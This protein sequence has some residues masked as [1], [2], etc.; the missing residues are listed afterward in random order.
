VTTQ[1]TA[2]KGSNRT[3]KQLLQ[4]ASVLDPTF[5]APIITAMVIVSSII[6]IGRSTS[7]TKNSKINPQRFFTVSGTLYYIEWLAFSG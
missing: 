5:A 2:I 7:E 6:I 1:A 3:A 4:K